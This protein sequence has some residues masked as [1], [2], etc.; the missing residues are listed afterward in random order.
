M[1]DYLRPGSQVSSIEA[2]Q[3]LKII[4]EMD[5]LPGRIEFV[6]ALTKDLDELAEMHKNVKEVTFDILLE[7]NALSHVSDPILWFLWDDNV[8]DFAF[9]RLKPG[10]GF[11]MPSARKGKCD[12]VKLAIHC[13]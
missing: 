13:N 3:I 4:A 2:S 9:L 6:K 1:V 12:L 8:P 10:N 7:G 11:S 5:N